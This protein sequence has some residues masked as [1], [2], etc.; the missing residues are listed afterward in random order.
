MLVAC[1]LQLEVSVAMS[2]SFFLTASIL[3]RSSQNE[4]Q[5]G[6]NL[7][8]KYAISFMTL[9][10][11]LLCFEALSLNSFTNS[12]TSLTTPS[13]LS[14][15]SLTWRLWIPETVFPSFSSSFLRRQIFPISWKIW[16][17]KYVGFTMEVL[18][19]NVS[20]IKIY[21]KKIYIV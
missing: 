13:N 9:F 7:K 4:E 8:R 14:S 6:L 5:L 1:C 20:P 17:P 10:P 2:Y 11:F 12:P 3:P 15:Q 18:P 16:E 21:I 19:T